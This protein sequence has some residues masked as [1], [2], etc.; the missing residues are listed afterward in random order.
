MK[1]PG[2]PE[3]TCQNAWAIKAYHFYGFLLEEEC[4][5][6]SGPL[7]ILREMSQTKALM[8]GRFILRKKCID[9]EMREPVSDGS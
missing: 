8:Y 2:G 3:D 7:W 5:F 1:K 9:T 6:S 4:S